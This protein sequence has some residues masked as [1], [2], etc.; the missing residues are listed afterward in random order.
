[1][2]S[3]RYFK[4]PT[5]CHQCPA[6]KRT[7]FVNRCDRRQEIAASVRLDD[8]SMRPDAQGVFCGLDRIVLTQENNSGVG[9][10]HA[11]L[12]RRLNAADSRERNVQKYDSGMKFFRFLDGLFTVR[13]FAYD[14]QISLTRKN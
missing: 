12:S 13:R 11:Y 5:S 10:N 9:R 3:W 8:V 2:L 6:N 14:I 7:T 4:T 1:M